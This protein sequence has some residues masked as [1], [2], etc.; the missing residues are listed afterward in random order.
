MNNNY[1]IDSLLRIK[2]PI[3][4]QRD[5]NQKFNYEIFK[6]HNHD[7]YKYRT[8]VF[9][10]EVN[11]DDIEAN[12]YGC[13]KNTDMNWIFHI[14]KLDDALTKDEQTQ[15]ILSKFKKNL[16]E[17]IGEKDI[18]K[19]NEIIANIYESLPKNEYTKE[20]NLIFNMIF[21]EK[22][23]VYTYNPIIFPT[24]CYI[25]RKLSITNTKCETALPTL[26]LSTSEPKI[27][28]NKELKLFMEIFSTKFIQDK[29]YNYLKDIFNFYG[30]NINEYNDISKTNY[31]K[32]ITTTAINLINR[33]EIDDNDLYIYSNLGKRFLLTI[34]KHF[35]E[36]DIDTQKILY[37]IIKLRSPTGIN[38]K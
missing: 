12:P 6:T 18:I 30:N 24:F 20:I 11:I 33:C 7:T 35:I 8:S 29:K 28:N 15:E 10:D 27:K 36:N 32:K 3:A 9:I 21:S 22:P 4:I 14:P 1:K 26:Y 13:F 2:F 38:D 16:M 31:T 37:N 34:S 25:L 5:I 23:I 19:N 17:D